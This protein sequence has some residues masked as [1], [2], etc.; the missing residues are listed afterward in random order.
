MFFVFSCMLALIVQGKSVFFFFFQEES[1]V[2][3]ILY[4]FLYVFSIRKIL[5]APNSKALSHYTT[6]AQSPFQAPLNGRHH[7]PLSPSAPFILCLNE[8]RNQMNAKLGLINL[9]LSMHLKMSRF[10][11]RVVEQRIND[12]EWNQVPATMDLEPRVTY[13]GG[14]SPR[15]EN[16][17]SLVRDE[18]GIQ[19]WFGWIY[20]TKYL[21]RFKHIAKLKI[22]VNFTAYIGFFYVSSLPLAAMVGGRWSGQ[23]NFIYDFRVKLYNCNSLYLRRQSRKLVRKLVLGVNG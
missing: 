17:D 8:T 18:S 11:I 19:Y 12:G 22:R 4:P 14:C 2:Q 21:K 10:Y 7:Y 15:F 23:V 13:A 16:L 1:L 6:A 3:L 20:L 5:Y 9:H